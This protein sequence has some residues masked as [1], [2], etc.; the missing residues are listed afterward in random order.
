MKYHVKW[1]IQVK[2]WVKELDR[3]GELTISIW[4][5][6]KRSS[7]IGN[8][9]SRLRV[10]LWSLLTWQMRQCLAHRRMLC[11]IFFQ[12]KRLVISLIVERILACDNP[13]ERLKIFWRFDY[14]TKGLGFL[15][16][17]SQW[18]LAP[19]VIRDMHSKHKDRFEVIASNSGSNSWL[20]P[21]FLQIKGYCSYL[22]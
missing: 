17:I 18:I 15:I 20:A 1:S 19:E 2:M 11:Q 3:E 14:G 21:S 8:E 7:G 22:I 12:M 4:I 6:R 10:W 9:E 5:F 13:W 16:E